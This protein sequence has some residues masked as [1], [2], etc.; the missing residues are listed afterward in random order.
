MT[1]QALNITELLEIRHTVKTN[2]PLI[3]C[4][5]NHISINDCANVVLSV[6]AKPIMAEH[7]AEVSAGDSNN[8]NNR[9]NVFF[10]G[11]FAR[12]KY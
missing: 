10:I 7:P 4:I 2:K 12:K 1:N 5:T 11:C 3:H 9:W 8:V 6:G